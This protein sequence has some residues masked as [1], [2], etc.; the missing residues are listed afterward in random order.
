MNAH[1]SGIKFER[2]LRIVNEGI[3]RGW[4]LGVQL[5]VASNDDC[6]LDLGIGNASFGLPMD[7]GSIALWFSSGKPVTAVALA[8]L[9]E[10]GWVGWDDPVARWIPDFAAHGKDSVTLRHVLTHTG[11]FRGADGIPEPT[12]WTETLF[13]ICE[14]P[15][16]PNSVPGETAAYH[17]HSSWS[18]LAEVVQRVSGEPFEER[19]RKRIFGPA[20]MDDSYVRTSPA[21]FVR[22]E[23]R[24]SKMHMADRGQMDPDLF[25]NTLE[26]A[27][28]LRP[29]AFL[30]GPIR[31]LG[32]FYQA[33][34]R[35]P[36]PLLR[37][38]T[39]ELMTRRHRE[40]KFDDTFKHVVDFGLGFII[41]SRRY[42]VESV[43]YG[44]GRHAGERAFGHGGQ[45]TSCGFADP[46]NGV[47]VAWVFNGLPGVRI[48]HRRGRELNTAIYEDL[49]IVR[50]D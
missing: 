38:E 21:E 8:Q 30:R 14:A 33:L 7:P 27:A 34:L 6:L 10:D 25:W 1:L 28:T 19:I 43:P 31:D 22:I 2:T 29:G 42:G 44:F 39:I 5:F 20:G 18:L 26:C 35:G 17:T 32:R 36:G 37:R 50:T 9:F 15:L 40:R 11:G 49:G 16:E 46:D 3:G 4:H 47:V 45:Q 24:L 13:R 12:P 41:N 48:H 23:N